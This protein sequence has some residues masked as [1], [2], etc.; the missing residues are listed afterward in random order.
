MAKKCAGQPPSHSSRDEI[1]P[2]LG[3]KNPKSDVTA[4]KDVYRTQLLAR[5]CSTGS[6][7]PRE[8]QGFKSVHSRQE[9]QK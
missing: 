5:W 2:H 4:Q 7:P 6:V 1:E 8:E 9:L 3:F